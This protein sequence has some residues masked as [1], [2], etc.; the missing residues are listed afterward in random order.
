MGRARI[1]CGLWLVVSVSLGASPQVFSSRTNASNT[2]D[3]HVVCDD[4]VVLSDHAACVEFN[5]LYPLGGEISLNGGEMKFARDVVCAS[6]SRWKTHGALYGNGH[7]LTLPHATKAYPFP[8]GASHVNIQSYARSSTLARMGALSLQKSEHADDSIMAVGSYDIHDAAFSL[9]QVNREK[10]ELLASL[11]LASGVRTI[12]WAPH[13]T[14]GLI[15]CSASDEGTL[16]AFSYDAKAQTLTK[17]PIGVHRKEVNQIQWSYDGQSFCVITQDEQHQLYLYRKTHTGFVCTAKIALP[18]AQLAPI[19]AM[20]WSF[21]DKYLILGLG[22]TKG[23]PQ[24][25]VYKHHDHTLTLLG[26]EA[27]TAHVSSITFWSGKKDYFFVGTA[28]T[29]QQHQGRIYRIE[30]DAIVGVSQLDLAGDIY[31]MAWHDQQN[32]LAV[33]LSPK[34]GGGEIAFY[35]WRDER[36][37]RIDLH[38]ASHAYY[39]LAWCP[40][41]QLL[42]AIDSEGSVHTFYL[43][44]Q[45]SLHDIT[46]ASRS[47]L[48]I[49][50]TL[51]CAGDVLLDGGGQQ[52]NWQHGA[53]LHIADASQL[54]MR[55]ALIATE[56]KLHICGSDSSHLICRDC[57]IKVPLLTSNLPLYVQKSCSLT[58]VI[59][60]P[61]IAQDGLHITID[62]TCVLKDV[63]RIQGVVHM[64]GGSGVLDVSEATFLLEPGAQLFLH[65]VEV[66]GIGAHQKQFRLQGEQSS[67][68]CKR[69]SL[70]M[71]DDIALA[72][73]ELILQGT[74]L[75]YQNEIKHVDGAIYRAK[76]CE[77][78]WIAA[79]LY[80]GTNEQSNEALVSEGGAIVIDAPRYQLRHDITLSENVPLRIVQN[81]TVIGNGHTVRGTQ[82]SQPLIICDPGVSVCFENCVVENIVPSNIVVGVDASLVWGDG[83]GIYLRGGGTLEHT[84]HVLG[85]VVIDGKDAVVTLASDATHGISV[86]DKSE[87]QLR[88]LSLTNVKNHAIACTSADAS[89]HL[90]GVSLLLSGDFSLDKGAWHIC[91]DSRFVG[92]YKVM[93]RSNQQSCIEQ[94]RTLSLEDG[95]TFIYQ[96]H[97][98]SPDRLACV[99][100]RSTLLL[101]NATIATIDTALKFLTGR[102]VC[103]GHA[104]LRGD[105]SGIFIGD[106]EKKLWGNV[107]PRPGS[108]V[109]MI[110]TVV[111][112]NMREG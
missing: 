6:S 37:E 22:Y 42:A 71:R 19:H 108:F 43:E 81:T 103:E 112:A 29:V 78:L 95:C 88:R 73:G 20:K 92:P 35:Q 56:N 50:V 13:S 23:Y 90:S 17:E 41:E 77:S 38:A 74:K 51:E 87:L 54:T 110:G 15:G 8:Q 101:R 33:A 70:W 104:T 84:W 96:P 107:I 5:S 100:D 91:R 94:D 83:C 59:D 75:C 48:D 18:S 10:R 76:E 89:L 66:K 64:H 99:G 26:S 25:L 12:A 65:D 14:N 40:H 3:H 85:N 55:N 39:R 30:D 61:I 4:G 86:G 49:N 67:I 1:A 80:G 44:A 34:E 58:G 106:K 2:I 31:D 57:S 46:V 24:L 47:P 98:G 53:G 72:R 68:H 111:V 45:L 28:G 21:D 9:Y 102:V 69:C 7:T 16:Y 52:V 97:D 63:V 82:T 11:S 105:G 79:G 60:A 32:I 109:H 93:Y 62:D 27:L 36:L